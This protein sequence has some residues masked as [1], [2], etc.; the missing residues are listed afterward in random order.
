MPQIRVVLNQSEQR[1]LRWLL[2]ASDSGRI[3]AG[4]DEVPEHVGNLTAL[5]GRLRLNET[6][7]QR[8]S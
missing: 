3:I 7:A 6:H 1:A 2:N 5:L 4:S 8:S